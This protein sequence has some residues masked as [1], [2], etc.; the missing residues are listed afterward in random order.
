MGRLSWG[1]SVATSLAFL[2]LSLSA[3]PAGATVV[4]EDYRGNANAGNAYTGPVGWPS[5]ANFVVDPVANL[6]TIASNP[7]N[8]IRTG[9]STDINFL[10]NTQQCN[11]TVS[12]GSPA[13]ALQVM[14]R[15]TYAL[16]RFPA[17]GSYTLSV[18]HDDNV[19]VDLS[20][21]YA[22]TSYRTASY[23]IPVGAL[24]NF[25]AGENDFVSVGTFS[26]AAA[27]SCALIR[28][29][30][31]NAGG[32]NYARLRWT[33]PGPVTEVIPATQLFDP[34]L[35][36]SATGCNGSITGNATAVTLNKVIGAPRAQ[37]TD[38]FTVEIGTTATAGTVLQATTSGAGT[39]QQ[40]STGAFPAVTGTTYYLRDLMAAGSASTLAGAYT[41]TIA[42]TRNGVAFTPAGA[43]PTWNVTTAA[44]NQIV[45]N[46]TNTARPILRLQKSLPVGRALATDQFALAIAGTGAGTGAAVTTT[47]ATNAPAQLALVSPATAGS[48][49]AFS[50]TAAAGANLANYSTTYAC[51]NTLPGGQTPAGNASSFNV[52]PVA[53]DNLTCTFSNQA[54]RPT[55]TLQKTTLAGFG[56]PFIFSLTNT[57]QAAGTAT[58]TAAGI[59]AQVDG[60]TGTAGLQVFTIATAGTAVVIAEAVPPAGYALSAAACTGMAS[61][62]TATADL[63][64]RT[65]T[66]D[67]AAT[68]AG[69]NIT[70]NFTNTLV[71][72]TFDF[73]AANTIYNIDQSGATQRAYR[74]TTNAPPELAL[75]AL[76]ATVPGASEFNGLMI[77]PVRNRLISV[78]RI[79]SNSQLWAYDPANGGWYAASATFPQSIPRAGMDANGVGYLVTGDANPTVLRVTAA[80]TYQYTVASLGT[81]TYSS[82]PTNATSGDIA[83]DAS[84]KGWMAVGQDLWSIDFSTLPLVAQR[85]QRP[86]LGGSPLSFA[87]AGIAFGSDGVLYVANSGAAGPVSSYYS[88][89]LDNGTMSL[90]TPASNARDLASCAFPTLAPVVLGLQKTLSTVNG[91]AYVAGAPVRAGD[92]MGYRIA[93]THTSGDLAATLY[94]GDVVETL[95]ANTTRV[96]SGN[97]FACTG[98]DCSN[99]GNVTI[100]VG[101]TAVLNFIIQVNANLPV[102]TTSIG[103]VVA[104][105]G[106]PGVDCAVNDC[107]ESTPVALSADLSITKSDGATQVLAGATVN[108]TIVV[109][110]A[111]PGN[112]HNSIMRDP[113]PAAGSGLS[114]TTDPT[115]SSS[116]GA[117]CPAPLTI[118]G[119]Q[120]AGLQVPLLPP[121]GVVTFGVSCQVTASGQ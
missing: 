21:D 112:A 101:G 111:G 63:P 48:V 100:P 57:T 46:I 51:A 5:Y 4:W 35:A 79:G 91:V 22:N 13:C 68:A 24:S 74:L 6:R 117:A 77:D 89:D 80:G 94:S 30:W 1:R 115:C 34:G 29:Y 28:M 54:A 119:L 16:V 118:A 20:S 36:S 98:S 87:L 81:M 49:Y 121:G 31:T 40:A 67:A 97:D 116:G 85:L 39:G 17:A 96:A 53:G 25:T 109:T 44:N 71:S 38:Q 56:G 66:L 58:T 15:V 72:P 105:N 83:F 84:G 70:C 102:G 45:C 33:R 95:P 60:D 99:S 50:E 82:T 52:T 19:D 107:V 110:N 12:P 73:C 23:N 7:A 8:A 26:A 78:A 86:T 64:N 120:G 114:C 113:A 37:A 42:C 3:A 93:L 41:S 88:I 76:N 62:G 90:V 10:S 92:V 47:G 27:N 61:G 104:V 14:G 59:A 106:E 18:A 65:I 103:N 32:L 9:S 69:A 2:M 108:Y 11:S 43:S 55:I 75:P